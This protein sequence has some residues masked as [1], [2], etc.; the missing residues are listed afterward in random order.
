M[1]IAISVGHGLHVRGASHPDGLDEVDEA[2]RATDMIAELLRIGGHDVH[3]FFDTVSTSQDENLQRITKWHNSIAT[4]DDWIN[5][6]THLNAYQ[7]TDGSR[8]CECLFVTQ[9]ELAT[10]L[11]AAMSRTLGLPNRGAHKRTDLYV[12][13]KTIAPAV[14]LEC[15]FVDANVDVENW[16]DAARFEACCQAIAD[17]LAPTLNAP[18]AGHPL[19]DLT[20]RVSWFGGKSDMGVDSDEPLAFIHDEDDT[21]GDIFYDAQ[22]PGT[23]GLAR[24]LDSEGSYYVA[25]RWDYD[26]TPR[27]QLLATQALVSAKGKSVRCWPADWGPHSSTSRIADVS[28]KT[29]E[30]LGVETDDTVTV[31]FPAPR[32]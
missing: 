2:I 10:E 8:G 1:K 11:A 24:K 4:D 31:I 12:L 15:C 16:Q 6:M 18:V 30:T 20:G 17:T 22:P 13:N 26:V 32:Q 23:T 14:L 27:E 5:V 28:L 25:C 21:D 3:Q 29:M 7:W 19:V 9:V